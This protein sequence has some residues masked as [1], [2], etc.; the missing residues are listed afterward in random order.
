[1]G[2][3]DHLAEFALELERGD[4]AR[5]HVAD[6]LSL[7]RSIND[8]QSAVW[9]LAHA[10]RLAALDG[11]AERAGLLWGAIEA[12]ESRGRIGQWEDQRDSYLAK[13]AGVPGRDFEQGRSQGQQLTLDQAVPE[14]IAG[15]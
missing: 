4:A 2:A 11:L 9:F 5:I 13:L 10:A 1:M 14:A 12:E 6:G 15:L 8:R 7:A 3:L